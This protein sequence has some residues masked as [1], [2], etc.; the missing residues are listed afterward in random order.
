MAKRNKGA[1]GMKYIFQGLNVRN[2]KKDLFILLSCELQ[3]DVPHK[4]KI[5]DVLSWALNIDP[6]YQVFDNL[7]A[8]KEKSKFLSGRFIYIIPEFLYFNV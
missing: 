7:L 4:A 8:A 5:S 1:R 2:N 3:P 6:N